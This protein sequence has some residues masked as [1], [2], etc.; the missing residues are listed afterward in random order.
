MAGARVIVSLSPTYETRRS[1]VL[2]HGDHKR[3]ETAQRRPVMMNPDLIDMLHELRHHKLLPEAEG[4]RAQRA[5]ASGRATKSRGWLVR[6][7]PGLVV[8]RLWAGTATE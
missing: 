3:S 1:D 8:R 5:G 2:G 4:E 7:L 6:W